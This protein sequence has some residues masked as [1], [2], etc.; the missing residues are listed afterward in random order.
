M[1]KIK[2]TV[3]GSILA[4]TALAASSQAQEPLLL[5]GRVLDAE[6][7]TPVYGAF[8]VPTTS[9]RGVLTDTLGV[10]ALMLEPALAAIDPRAL[11][12]V[13]AYGRVGVVRMYTVDYM[14]WLIDSGQNLQPLTFGCRGDRTI[15]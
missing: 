2:P 9:E 8:V 5:R 1:W 7:R 6:S 13:E 15:G 4:L 3:L 12:A 11:Y 10:F 14:K